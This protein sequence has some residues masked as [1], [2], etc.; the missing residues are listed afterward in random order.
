[1]KRVVSLLH[2]Q[3]VRAKAEGLFFNVRGSLRSRLAFVTELAQGLHARSIQEHHGSQ[4]VFTE[5]PALQGPCQPDPIL[6]APVLQGRR[7]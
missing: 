1:M 3:G 7:G 2:R 4:T 6:T 5:G